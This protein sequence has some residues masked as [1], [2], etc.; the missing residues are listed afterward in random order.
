MVPSPA[1]DFAVADALARF[2]TAS[3]ELMA[4]RALQKR[5]DRKYLVPQPLIGT[6]LE[7]LAAD[8]RV[9]HAGDVLVGRYETIYFDTAD[10]QLFDDHRRGR[11]PRYKVRLR[12]HCDRR[13]T[14]VEVKQKG[15]CTS[16]ARL[17]MPFSGGVADTE[18]PAMPWQTTL[19]G[20]AR[21]FVDEHCP[22]P[23]DRLMPLVWVTFW[24]L[25]LVGDG[26]HERL[27][28]DWN[29]EFGD[30]DTTERLPGLVIAEVK[31][32]GFTNSSPAIEAFGCLDLR[33]RSLS[34][35]CL[36]TLRL[37]SARAHSFRTGLQAA[38]R[39]TA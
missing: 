5:V 26:I 36:A 19:A 10:R 2:D 28:F 37:A 1:N 20:R 13:L 15:G 24:R 7:R 30:R 23:A 33:E 16:K 12:H 17:E 35:Y 21:Q 18:T 38:E 3:P 6:V 9:A 32:A 22:I 4:A 8:Y 14:F 11:R 31:Q 29:I 27:T 25:T 34:K 39:L